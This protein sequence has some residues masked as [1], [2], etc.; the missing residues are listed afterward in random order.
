MIGDEAGFLVRKAH[1]VEQRGD[2]VGMVL[3]A[4]VALVSD[5]RKWRK[6]VDLKIRTING[7]MRMP[8]DRHP[9]YGDTLSGERYTSS[10]PFM[11]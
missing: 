4:K 10:L 7:W 6:T 2:I 9:P 1:I 11:R 5:M 3:H 8:P